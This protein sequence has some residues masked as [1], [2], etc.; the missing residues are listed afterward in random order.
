MICFLF[1]CITSK[2][3]PITGRKTWFNYCP[4]CERMLD[5]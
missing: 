4:R 2:F 3:D 5:R 1:G